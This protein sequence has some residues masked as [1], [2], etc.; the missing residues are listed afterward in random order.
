[1]LTTDILMSI[2]KVSIFGGV[3]M[4]FIGNILILPIKLIL[5]LLIVIV[6]FA[7]MILSI[8]AFFGK[9]LLGLLNVLVFIG[10]IGGIVSGT[11]QIAI[12]AVLFLCFSLIG[13]LIDSFPLFLSRMN[14]KMIQLLAFRF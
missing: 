3:K 8:F 11:P 5:L 7:N 12:A 14:T 4:K 9:F 13:L 10:L 2:I 6:F 1:M